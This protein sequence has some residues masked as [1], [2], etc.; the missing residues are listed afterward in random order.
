MNKIDNTAGRVPTT[1]R[2]L[3]LV[4]PCGE[5]MWAKN[6]II[7]HNIQHDVSIRVR[8]PLTSLSAALGPDLLHEGWNA[9][10]FDR[11]CRPSRPVQKPHSSHNYIRIKVGIVN[12][13]TREGEPPISYTW[14]EVAQGSVVVMVHLHTVRPQV[15][16]LLWL[17]SQVPIEG[18]NVKLTCGTCPSW[19]WSSLVVWLFLRHR[20]ST[21]VRPLGVHNGR[22]W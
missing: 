19:R 18:D 10:R 12:R 16:C 9:R 21:E 13:H 20:H 11:N 2:L 1:P 7:I 4:L 22:C 15:C 17:Q 6:H 5:V 3:L 14:N 8:L